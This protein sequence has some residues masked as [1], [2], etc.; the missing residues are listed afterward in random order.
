MGLKCNYTDDGTAE[1]SCTTKCYSK[2]LSNGQLEYGCINNGAL[3]I[4]PKIM[5]CNFKDFCNTDICFTRNNKLTSCTLH[6]EPTTT[7]ANK[8]SVDNILFGLPWPAV[9]T[10]TT[11]M[12]KTTSIAM[13]EC[14]CS[15]TSQAGY[16]KGINLIKPPNCFD[17]FKI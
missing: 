5:C 11:V 15:Q 9:K 16:E 17:K 8:L 7:A 1:N 3:C 6:P 12:F 14:I 2:L 10:S 13:S 4:N